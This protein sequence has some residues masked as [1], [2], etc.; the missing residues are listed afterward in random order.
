MESGVVS[1][2]FS[3]SIF[4]VGALLKRDMVM[5]LIASYMPR[6]CFVCLSFGLMLPLIVC[7]SLNSLIMVSLSR[8]ALNKKFLLGVG[9]N[10]G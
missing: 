6:K 1:S 10:H 4:C 5:L 2:S 7:R 8:C 9:L 3:V